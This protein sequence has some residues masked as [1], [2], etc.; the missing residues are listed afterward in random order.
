MTSD[1][2]KIHAS[3]CPPRALAVHCLAVDAP[4]QLRPDGPDKYWNCALEDGCPSM[5]RFPCAKLAHGV[6]P[7]DIAA[8]LNDVPL[9]NEKPE[10]SDGDLLYD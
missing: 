3:I 5:L 2:S 8:P 4:V 6:T 9:P 10:E 1:I 7:A